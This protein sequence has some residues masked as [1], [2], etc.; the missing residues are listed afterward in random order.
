MRQPPQAL[1]SRLAICRPDEIC[2]TELTRAELL[3]GAA[4]SNRADELRQIVLRLI[5]P[6]RCL[7]FG[8][9]AVEHYVSIRIALEK[10]G[11]PVSSNDLLIA[12][13]ARAAGVTLITANTREFSRVPNLTCED[14]TKP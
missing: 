12:A 11:T 4:H 10:S 6:Y 13:T 7:P 3:F 14:W 1:A 8:G 5:S 9:T 2:L